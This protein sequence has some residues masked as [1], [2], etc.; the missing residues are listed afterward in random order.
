MESSTTESKTLERDYR[1]LEGLLTNIVNALPIHFF[2][3]DT[4][5]EYRYVY[6]SPL[7]KQLY[8]RHHDA[9]AGKTDFDLFL[10]P[11]VAQS[12]RD[13]DEEIVRLG[14]M[15]RFVEQM[16]D[17]QGVLRTLD[18]M[19]L[20]VPREDGRQPFL[21]GISWDITKQ[22]QVEEEM[23]SYNKRLAIACQAGKIYPWIWDMV[24]GTAELS[25]TI[26]GKIEHICIEHESFTEKIH[27][28]YQQM[29][30]DITNA[31][32]NG[33]IDSIRFSFPCQYFTDEYIWY[34]KIGEVYEADSEGRTIKSIGILRDMTVD[35]RHEADI[36]AKHLA[37]ESDRMKSA[38]IAN[39]SHEIRTPLNAIVG[40]S[41]LLAQSDDPDEKQ[42]FL[43]I[44][45]SSNEFLLQLIGDILDISKIESGKLEF[46][47]SAFRLN[48]IFAPQ[49]QAFALRVEP[50]VDVIFESDGNDYSIV[51]EKTR[52]TQVLTNFLSNAVKF[53]SSGTIRYGYRLTDTG[54]YAYVA[55][56]GAGIDQEHQ[57]SIFNRFVKLNSFK[58]GTGLG[59]SIC[60]T[61]IEKLKGEIGVES[62]EGKGSTFWFSIPCSPMKVK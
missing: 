25:V 1:D 31:F 4:G 9:V 59:L 2:V 30:R 12:F 10:D 27:P 15:Q 32:A 53:T 19:K 42:E 39:M 52:L 44:I 45:E 46:I 56:T 37:E 13:M 41:T 21:V 18:T 23:H 16:I 50:G 7:M 38:F 35:K 26:N 17:P 5:N 8:G 57:S 24:N 6:S 20:L 61:I 40:F 34:E 22:R 29:Y 49:Q 28:S 47:Y 36:R 33:E 48:D 60:K 51:S 3:K 11:V 55:D 43:K 62:E 14:K 58:Q 54:L